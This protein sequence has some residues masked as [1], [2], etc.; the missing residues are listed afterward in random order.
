MEETSAE[1][2][3]NIKY[4][5]VTRRMYNKH[6]K[7]ASLLRE[8]SELFDMKP[9][10]FTFESWLKINRIIGFDK[11]NKHAN[12]KLKFELDESIPTS[13]A[14][15]QF[16]SLCRY[17]VGENLESIFKELKEVFG[18]HAPSF[19]QLSD[20]IK[21]FWKGDQNQDE[22]IDND[23][24]DDIKIIDETPL[25]NTITKKNKEEIKDD[26]INSLK[27]E[28]LKLNEKLKNA[29]LLISDYVTKFSE[30]EANLLKE[31]ETKAKELEDLKSNYNNSLAFI[32]DLIKKLEGYNT[33]KISE[34]R[35]AHLINELNQEILEHKRENL[36][37]KNQIEDM[38]RTFQ[39]EKNIVS[40]MNLELEQKLELSI[41]NEIKLR[42]ELKSIIDENEQILNEAKSFKI[43]NK[44]L[45]RNSKLKEDE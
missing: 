10:R 44:L 8:L 13:V 40:T 34:M 28:N 15:I 5:V 38:K 27:K 1:K 43:K 17:Q 31:R 3:E 42:E 29:E 7:V 16:Y 45:K 14:K 33:V 35:Y 26:S 2:L 11:H 12:S 22:V 21:R 39:C 9:N 6:L 18:S 30:F 32:S 37:L 25:T 24:L 23:E 4:Y 20:W 19:K 36:E 41:K